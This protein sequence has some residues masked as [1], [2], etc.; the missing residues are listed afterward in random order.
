MRLTRKIDWIGH[1]AAKI[2]QVFTEARAKQPTLIFIDELDAVCPPRGFYYD[3][4]AREVTARF[5][6]EIDGLLSA[7]I[8]EKHLRRPNP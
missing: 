2:K 7:K 5:L 1:G 8:F 6:Q 3:S 4:I